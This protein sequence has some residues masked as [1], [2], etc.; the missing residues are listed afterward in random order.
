MGETFLFSTVEMSRLVSCGHNVFTEIYILSH[1]E[2]RFYLLDLVGFNLFI[3][4]FLYTLL[5]D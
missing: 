1:I 4:S 2:K 3:I 5:Q